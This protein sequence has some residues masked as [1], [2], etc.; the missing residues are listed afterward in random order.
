MIGEVSSSAESGR[1]VEETLGWGLFGS[2]VPSLKTV[3]TSFPEETTVESETR[4]KTRAEAERPSL[5]G[6]VDSSIS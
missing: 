4:R 5:P 2:L 6:E 1:E 3:V